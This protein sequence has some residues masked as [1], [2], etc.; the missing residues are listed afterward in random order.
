MTA[1]VIVTAVLLTPS[2]IA[3]MAVRAFVNWVSASR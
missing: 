2:V 1:L 3:H